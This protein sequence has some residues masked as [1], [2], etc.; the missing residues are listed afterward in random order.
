M[1]EPTRF[2]PSA[3]VRVLPHRLHWEVRAP[4]L[5]LRLIDSLC[6]KERAIEHAVAVAEE[7]RETAGLRRVVV[8]VERADGSIELQ[9]AA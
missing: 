8:A 5:P 4:G 7:L 1:P 6:T 9:I 2:A 3:V